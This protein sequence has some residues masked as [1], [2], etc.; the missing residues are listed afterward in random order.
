MPKK[1][2]ALLQAT[3]DLENYISR[4]RYNLSK[5]KTNP[6]VPYSLFVTKVQHFNNLVKTLNQLFATLIGADDDLFYPFVLD[7]EEIEEFTYEEPTHINDMD[8]YTDE[9]FTTDVEEPMYDMESEHEAEEF[10]EKEGIESEESNNTNEFDMSIETEVE[11]DEQEFEFEIS[12]EVRET[13][14]GDLDDFDDF[15]DGVQDEISMKS[16]NDMLTDY[17]RTSEQDITSYDP[18]EDEPAEVL[19]HIISDDD[20]EEDEDDEKEP[21]GIGL[22]SEENIKYLN[23]TADNQRVNDDPIQI[24]DTLTAVEKHGKDELKGTDTRLTDLLESNTVSFD[25]DNIIKDDF[26]KLYVGRD[27]ELDGDEVDISDSEE[28]LDEEHDVVDEDEVEEGIVEYDKDE[29]EL[30][31]P[32]DSDD[33]FDVVEEEPMDEPYHDDNEDDEGAVVGLHGDDGDTYDE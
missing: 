7:G 21:N 14:E 17:E 25:V 32:F 15:D 3:R 6:N 2:F 20:S 24:A 27:E 30:H 29:G 19:H 11:D 1:Q 10:E 23:H 33:D 18:E 13:I 12:E 5:M 28:S 9:G 8:V 26:D 31:E 22:L 16:A 4:E